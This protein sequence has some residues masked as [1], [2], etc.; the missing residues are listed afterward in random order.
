MTNDHYVIFFFEGLGSVSCNGFIAIIRENIGTN[1]WNRG[2]LL[3]AVRRHM[4]DLSSF[5]FLVLFFI[6]MYGPNGDVHTKHIQQPQ[7]GIRKNI[8]NYARAQMGLPFHDP[9]RFK[10]NP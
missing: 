6:F 9:N 2:T 3:F 1:I 5:S 7:Y 8:S 10:L 4:M